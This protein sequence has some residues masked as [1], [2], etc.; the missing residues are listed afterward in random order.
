MKF[1]AEGKI[2]WLC[3]VGKGSNEFHLTVAVSHNRNGI[4]HRQQDAMANASKPTDIEESRKTWRGQAGGAFSCIVA[5]PTVILALRNDSTTTM[6]ALPSQAG[7][8]HSGLQLNEAAPLS[9]PRP[10]ISTPETTTSVATINR[11]KPT[12]LKLAHTLR[13]WGK[14]PNNTAKIYFA[15]AAQLQLVACLF[16][17][18]TATLFIAKIGDF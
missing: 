9:S 5:V 10:C 7:Y 8:L 16:S 13:A 4:L 14:I 18:H 12:S 3:F 6:D 15:T 2:C 1:E 11:G 17:F